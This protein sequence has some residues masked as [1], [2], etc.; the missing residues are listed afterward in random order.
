MFA[1]KLTHDYN[2]VLPLMLAT[3]A[4]FVA[5]A[6]LDRDFMTEKLAG[7]LLA[8]CTRTDILRVSAGR[9]EAER[10]QSEWCHGCGNASHQIDAGGNT[11]VE[12]HEP[13][14]RVTNAESDA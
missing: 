2:A 13:D 7:H 5:R 12:S 1:F 11:C 10:P 4:E 6:L 3:F 9:R 14:G 8:I